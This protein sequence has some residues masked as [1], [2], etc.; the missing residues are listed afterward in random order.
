MFIRKK[1]FTFLFLIL[2]VLSFSKIKIENNKNL[3]TGEMKNGMKYYIYQNKM[4]K[5][6]A[7]V[8]VL[9]NA[10]SLQ[11][12]EDQLGMAHLIEHLCFNGTEK[13]DKNEV[14]KYY[15]SIGMDFGGDLNAHTSFNET[16][17]KIQI[18]TD[19]KKTFEKGIEVLKEMTLKPTFKQEEIN[20]EKYIVREEWRLGQGLN[21]RM[22]KLVQKEIFGNSR[23]GKRFP[24]GDMDIIMGTKRNV[25]KR[26]YDRWYHP[27]NMAVVLVGD[28]DVNYAKNV[29]EKYFDIETNREFTPSKEY[30]LN[31]LNNKYVVFK[32]K[33]LTYFLIEMTTKQNINYTNNNEKI[34]DY[35]KN[36]I[37]TS[38]MQ[39][40]FIEEAK[41]KNNAIFYGGFYNSDFNTDRLNTYYAVLS[42]DKLEYGIQQFVKILK[43]LA[44]N[45]VSETELEL[46]KKNI[47]IIL[48]NQVKNK[49]SVTSNQLISKIRKIFLN[50]DIFYDAND[51][52]NYFNEISK[53]IT[54][55]DIKKM[56][57]KFYN[58]KKVT[59]LFAPEMKN[60]KIP[61]AKDLESIITKEMS[62]KIPIN[63]MDYSIP[64]L[65]KP[66]IVPGKIIET[67]NFKNYDKI[68][69]SNG[70]TFLYKE[71]NFEK[72]R[73]Y[74]DLFKQEGSYKDSKKLYFNSLF[75]DVIEDSGAGNINYNNINK[76]MK[77]K[78]FYVSPYIDNLQQGITI[79][80]S[81]ND[82][83]TALDYSNYVATKPNFDKPVYGNSFT[84]TKEHLKNRLNSPKAIYSDKICEV[85]FNNDYRKRSMNL[86]DLKN[87]SKKNILKEYRS[88]IGDFSGYQGIIVGAISKKEA[89]EI[90]EKY[91]ASL[92][93]KNKNEL[94]EKNYLD[95]KYPTHI[96]KYKVIKG[97]TKKTTVTLFYPINKEYTQDNKYKILAF[98]GLLDIDLT[99][100]IR[101]RLGGVYGVAAITKFSE[102]ENPYL[103]II[104]STDPERAREITEAVKDEIFKLVDGNINEKS[105]VSI[106]KNYNLTYEDNQNKNGYWIS[107]L[108]RKA[109]KGD[110]YEP[111][112][113]Q[114]YKEEITKE[115]LKPFFK[116]LIN[117]NNYIEV[118]LIPEKEEN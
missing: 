59:I 34:K 66:K 18:P 68:K 95:I 3:I 91:F 29:L 30:K 22:T 113:P 13:Y 83:N 92:P 40:R 78:E 41:S 54:T 43:E 101:E 26:F 58:D 1:I 93:V 86:K 21:D 45:K 14:I 112:S 4:P 74:I 57:E 46:E 50:N 79:I 80:S 56:A 17:Y 117:K 81:K 49:D 7:A 76:F 85:M 10:G 94:V 62:K 89:N 67:N 31:N 36:I 102:Y 9:V 42:Q 98:N 111:Y 103:K 24:I 51:I 53:E 84:M 64:T 16:V 63:K 116:G 87:I 108:K 55:K 104:F 35:F 77:G 88:K 60:V 96:K 27:K 23:Y 106:V 114:K 82:L 38:F 61:T 8:N 28:I 20:S 69:L 107:Y 115:K 11:E 32:D 97:D 5:N 2:S 105:L 110:S 6:R 48:E 118:M 75:I 39:N 25:L 12:D 99:D 65:N 44:T 52:L 71:T 90:L 73:I 15:Q 37:L 109:I 70:I 19:N 47:K 100:E 33:E 72:D